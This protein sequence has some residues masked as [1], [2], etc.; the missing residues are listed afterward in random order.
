M[1]E[2]AP[3]GQVSG[4]GVSRLLWVLS[5]ASVPQVVLFATVCTGARL[6]ALAMLRYEARVRPRWAALPSWAPGAAA[7]ATGAAVVLGGWRWIGAAILAAGVYLLVRSR[8]SVTFAWLRVVHDVLEGLQYAGI[9]VFLLI[10]PF[11][12]QTFEIPSPSM[13]PTLRVR[14]YVLVDKATYRF[15]D[16]RP[17]EV[18]VFDAPIEATTVSGGPSGM[19]VKRL[20]GG[21]GDVVEVVAGI[22]YRNGVPLHEPY[23]N[24]TDFGDFKLVKY[25][26]K[27]LPILRDRLGQFP[28][29]TLY[30][31]SV[32]PKDLFRVWDLPAE[33]LPPGTYFALGDNRNNSM[34][35]RH[36]G[37]VR[38]EDIVGRAW[39]V[40]FP[41]TRVGF[42][43]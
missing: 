36:W 35:S 21:P 33:P 29:G 1:N 6:A 12:V 18:A 40:F 39:L 8:K 23:I 25:K 22:L 41:L 30:L 31:Q 13:E 16:P 42:V 27:L 43:R 38:R 20:I 2:W 10:R 34:D 19:Y 14:D 9:V 15:R 28:G 5:S 3:I 17:G 32:P 11:L 37:L 26:G 4:D 24:D 7:I